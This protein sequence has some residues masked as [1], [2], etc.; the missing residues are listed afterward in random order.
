MYLCLILVLIVATISETVSAGNRINDIE[1]EAS[2]TINAGTNTFAPYYISSLAH[3]KITASKGGIVDMWAKHAVDTA[4]RFS[5]GAGIEIYGGIASKTA[6]LKYNSNGDAYFHT[7]RPASFRLQQLYAE[8]KYRSLFLEAGLRE[9]GSALLDNSLTSGDLVE[10]GNATPIPQI[11]AGFIDFRDIPLTKGWLQIQGELGYGKFAD[12][13]WLKDFYSY[14]TSHINLGAFYIYRRA[15]FRTKPSERFVVTFGLQSAGQI[16]GTSEWYS[17]GKLVYS[18]HQGTTIWDLV[19]MIAP[20]T[21]YGTGKGEY[22]D[23][24]N[25][26]SWDIMLRYN[27][28]KTNHRITGYLQKPWEKGSSVGW[29]NGWDGLWGIEYEFGETPHIVDAVLF[30]YLYFMNHSGPI[31]FAPHDRPGTDI[32]SDI[33]GQDNYYNNYAYNSYENYGVSMGTPFLKSPIYNTDGYPNF[34]D[35]RVKGFHIASRGHIDRL[36]Q[37][38]I[39]LSYRKA[40]G[41]V[42]LPRIE[43]VDDFSWLAEVDGSIKRLPDLHVKLQ[44]AMDRGLLLG[45][46]FGALINISYRG[47]FSYRKK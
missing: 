4:K 43:I 28:P 14:E 15:Y 34:T 10:S 36:W 12:N 29:G 6:Y 17:R 39:A 13:G 18:E 25:L 5:W 23:G 19:K 1:W 26:G 3:G 9:R 47:G 33:T 21:T 24:N 11:R 8:I 22:F 38:K 40:Y 41:S 32:T 46:N 30:E 42:I 2:I 37:W 20:F 35:N 45:N 44:V 7:M 31:H 27:I 16:G